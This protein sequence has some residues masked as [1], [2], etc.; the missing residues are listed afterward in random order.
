MFGL[1]G[2]IPSGLKLAFGIG[3]IV[4]VAAAWLHYKSVVSDRDTALAEVGSLTLA[5]VVQDAT[6]SEQKKALDEWKESTAAFQKK[7]AELTAAQ[8]EASREARRLNDVL[9][10]HDLHALSLAKPGL[11]EP[12]INSGTADILRLFESATGSN[13]RINANRPPGN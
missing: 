13:D 6:I 9:A 11:I 7:L 1:L 2:M 5:K 12:R 10:R 3:L 4:A 8:L